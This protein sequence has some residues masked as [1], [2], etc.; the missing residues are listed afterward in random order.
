MRAIASSPSP[1][2][3][4]PRRLKNS[5]RQRCGTADTGTGRIAPGAL[6]IRARS[7]APSVKTGIV[8]EPICIGFHEGAIV[9]HQIPRDLTVGAIVRTARLR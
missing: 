2:A 7:A 8:Q 3:P 5:I 6:G 9:L 4:H 1:W